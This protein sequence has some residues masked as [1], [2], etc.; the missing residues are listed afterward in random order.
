MSLLVT[1]NAPGAPFGQRR[2][3]DWISAQQKTIEEKRSADIKSTF[4][5]Q[6]EELVITLKI[7]VK[8]GL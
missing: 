4:I 1:P 6:R 7:Q 5:F 2:T 3:G 8:S